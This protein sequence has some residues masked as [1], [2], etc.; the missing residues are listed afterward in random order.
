MSGNG[1]LF[2][3]N[4][5]STETIFEY[6]ENAPDKLGWIVQLDNELNALT[7]FEV[8]APTGFASSKL[9]PADLTGDG[10]ADLVSIGLYAPGSPTDVF[11]FASDFDWHWV[12]RFDPIQ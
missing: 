3:A 2:W 4:I 9:S 12:G 6:D 7:Q 8:Y 5:I 11:Y 1:A 10:I